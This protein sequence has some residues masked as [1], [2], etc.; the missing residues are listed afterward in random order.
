[1]IEIGSVRVVNLTVDDAVAFEN[2]PAGIPE[3]A[4]NNTIHRHPVPLILGKKFAK[5]IH[6]P[7]SE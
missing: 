4:I 2:E 5:E 7:F 3:R 6:Y 1:M